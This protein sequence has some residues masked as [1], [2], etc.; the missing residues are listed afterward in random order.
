M[1]DGRMSLDLKND[2]Y[3]FS[4]FE[5]IAKWYF[6][7]LIFKIKI[8]ENADLAVIWW[9]VAFC[10]LANTNQKGDFYIQLQKQ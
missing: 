2:V 3:M 8:K 10:W 7:S 5:E 6:D 4:Y 1:F 9:S